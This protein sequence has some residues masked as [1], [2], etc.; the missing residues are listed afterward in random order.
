[1]SVPCLDAQ[2][3]F[4]PEGAVAV[5]RGVALSYD[6][7]LRRRRHSQHTPQQHAANTVKDMCAMLDS[8]IFRNERPH[9]AAGCA[10]HTHA[11]NMPVQLL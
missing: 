8:T 10:S 4:L 11:N 3:L 5:R 7:R 6:A 9:A 1:M 2:L